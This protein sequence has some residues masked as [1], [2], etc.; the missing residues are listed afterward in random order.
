MKREFTE[1]E[2]RRQNRHY[3]GTGGVSQENHGYGFRPAFLDT[4]TG[5]I[6]H[7]CYADGRPAPC[8][9]LEGLPETLVLARA[10]HGRIIAIKASVIAGFARCG[11]FYTREEAAR[12]V[13]VEAGAA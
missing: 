7:S 10:P 13:L 9:L 11:C 5:V 6:Y 12:L 4:E 8:H 1:H 2:L 3:R